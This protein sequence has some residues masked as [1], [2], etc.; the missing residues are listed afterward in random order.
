M[1]KF[2][3]GSCLIWAWYFTWAR[4]HILHYQQIGQHLGPHYAYPTHSMCMWNRQNPICWYQPVVSIEKK[5]QNR[6][7]RPQHGPRTP[8]SHPKTGSTPKAHYNSNQ[9]RPSMTSNGPRSAF[10]I[11][12]RKV[13][14]SRLDSTAKKKA[15]GHADHPQPSM[16]TTSQPGP[17]YHLRFGLAQRKISTVKRAWA[18]THQ[19]SNPGPQGRSGPSKR[20]RATTHPRSGLGP[21][22]NGPRIQI[23][24][25]GQAHGP[26]ISPKK[27][28]IWPLGLPLTKSQNPI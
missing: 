9:S 8:I 27:I 13:V 19:P 4:L 20:A 3:Q 10:G 14:K 1:Q 21:T 25:M 15:H 26:P 6:R 22:E 28:Q 5:P 7:S 12:P 17:W 18:G 24:L 16:A 11:D 2:A 23:G